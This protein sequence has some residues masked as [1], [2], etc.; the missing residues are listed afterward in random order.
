MQ[1][2]Y[3][4]EGDR[5]SFIRL[6]D[7]PLQQERGSSEMGVVD[8]QPRDPLYVVCQDEAFGHAVQLGEGSGFILT[9]DLARQHNSGTPVELD[10]KWREI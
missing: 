10:G 5:L 8:F 1:I 3:E 4:Y 6:S 7:R 9:D 2:Y